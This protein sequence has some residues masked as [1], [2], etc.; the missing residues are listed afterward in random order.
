MGG[1]N[2]WPEERSS[3]ASGHRGILHSYFEIGCSAVDFS[4]RRPRC[5]LEGGWNPRGAVLMKSIP[6]LISGT[7]PLA[8]GVA[9]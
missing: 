8:F 6:E 2:L 4:R 3:K 9:P 5:G 1:V 7:T